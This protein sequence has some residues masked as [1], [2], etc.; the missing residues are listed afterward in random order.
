MNR[1]KLVAQ[2]LANLRKKNP[3]PEYVIGYLSSLI[4]RLDEKT[5]VEIAK[6]SA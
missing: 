3:N 6:E 5:L 2:I 1:E 4:I